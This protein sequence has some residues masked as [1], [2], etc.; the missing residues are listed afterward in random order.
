M[1]EHNLLVLC[2]NF[3]TRDNSYVRGIFIKDQIN[4]LKKYFDNI[5]VVTPIEYGMEYRRKCRYEDYSFDNVRVFFK[6]YMNFPLFWYYGRSMWEAL[7]ERAVISLIKDKQLHFD[8]IHAHFTWP[9]GNVAIQLKKKWGVP[10]VITEHWNQPVDEIIGEKGR[11]YIDPWMDCDALIRVNKR[12]LPLIARVGMDPSKVHP[13]YSGY[14]PKK[15]YPIDRETAR[16]A[17]H[18]PPGGKIILNIGRLDPEKGLSYLISAI[19]NIIKV[20]SDIVCYIGGTGSIRHELEQ[21]IASLNLQNHV[22]LTGFVPDDQMCLW[23]NAADIFVLPSLLESGP[24]TMFET[25]SCGKQFVG[26]S[27]GAVP[28]VIVSNEYGRIV[29]P[30]DTDDLTEKI[31][32]ALDTEADREAIISY[33]KQFTWENTAKELFSIYQHVLDTAGTGRDRS[34][35]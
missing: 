33:A 7:E 17:L 18:L 8:L 9:A 21:Q 24:V 23:M 10:V 3:P 32:M 34:F 19:N 26:T 2:H 1:Q 30:A 4:Y 22:K 15:Y 29:K 6:K 12:D 27:V 16:M 13:V 35:P 28:E 31:L 20:R 11:S 5:Y 14:D 25:L